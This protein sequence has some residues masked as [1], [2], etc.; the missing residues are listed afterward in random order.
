M[1]TK[2]QLKEVFAKYGFTPLKRLGENYLIDGNIKD[3]IIRECRLSKSDSVLEIGP[4]LGALTMDLAASAGRVFAVEI[5]KKAYAILNELAGGDYPNLEIFNEDILKFDLEEI[6]SGGRIK[7]VANLPYY[8]TTPVI[9]Y[10]INNRRLLESAVIMIQKEVAS[11]LLA[12]PGTK[13][14]SSISCFVRYFTR[15]EYIYTVKRASFFPSPDVDSSILRLTFLDKPSVSVNDEEKFFK[16]VRGA[17]NQR[18][19]SIINSLARIEVLDMP[20]EKLSAI[21]NSIGIDPAARPE[22]LNLTRFAAIS[23]AF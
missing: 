4:G 14:Y 6:A 21:L 15:P 2:T 19:K 8:I 20:K 13:D 18:R 22:T 9:E 12:G 7:V 16:I 1:L 17:F 23:N 3:K 10:L 11:R 5:D